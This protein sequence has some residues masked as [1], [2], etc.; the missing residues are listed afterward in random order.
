[1]QRQA[2]VLSRLV[3]EVSHPSRITEIPHVN[4]D[5][6]GH[7]QWSVVAREWRSE[8][9]SM[10]AGRVKKAYL[11]LLLAFEQSLSQDCKV[12]V[13]KVQPYQ[14]ALPNSP[15][16]QHQHACSTNFHLL[17]LAT[18]M[19]GKGV[20]SKSVCPVISRSRQ[21]VTACLLDLYSRLF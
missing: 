7:R 4:W 10:E 11:K 6:F 21:A 18:G 1:M 16:K 3:F 14:T 12:E 2:S 9:G 13:R 19:A 15:A 5:C 8:M 20:S 17:H